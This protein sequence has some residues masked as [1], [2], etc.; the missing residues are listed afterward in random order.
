MVES[1]FQIICPKNSE[2]VS[3]MRLSTQYPAERKAIYNF[4]GNWKR[5][6]SGSQQDLDALKTFLRHHEATFKSRSTSNV[7][8][9]QWR[10]AH[11]LRYVL[12]A[13]T[14]ELMALT[15]YA[16]GEV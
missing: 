14:L 12:E 10:R 1:V 8:N 15:G 4:H 11:H 7:E 2:N 6:F 9:P 13:A 5:P 16:D 3:S